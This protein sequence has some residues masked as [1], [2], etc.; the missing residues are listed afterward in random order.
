MLLSRASVLASAPRSASSSELRDRQD[1]SSQ[2][3]KEGFYELHAYL[4]KALT[5]PTRLLIIDELRAGPRSVSELV[6]RDVSNG[7]ALNRPPYK[8]CLGKPSNAKWNRFG[9][10]DN[11]RHEAP[12]GAGACHVSRLLPPA[13]GYQRSLA[14]SGVSASSSLR[15]SSM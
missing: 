13:P 8:N 10:R 1:A 7:T 12:Q 11:R 14:P 15:I 9:H 5:H 6:Q 3:S 2:Q 4:C